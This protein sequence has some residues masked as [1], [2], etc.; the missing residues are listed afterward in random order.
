MVVPRL[1]VHS[2]VRWVVSNPSDGP[3]ITANPRHPTSPPARLVLAPFH[4]SLPQAILG[5]LTGMARDGYAF[6]AK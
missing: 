4:P 1:T 2:I 5:I 3:T 6:C